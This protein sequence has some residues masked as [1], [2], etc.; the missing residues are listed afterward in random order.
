MTHATLFLVALLGHL[1]LWVALFNRLHSLAIP[2]RVQD[3]VEKWVLGGL[4]GGPALVVWAVH[5]RPELLFHPAE[6]LAGTPAVLGYAA[7]C[8]GMGTW[9]TVRWLQRKLRGP[10]AELLSQRREVSRLDRELGRLPCSDWPTRAWARVPGNQLLQVEVATKSL[11]IARLP[12]ALD[13]LRI[14]HLSDLHFSGRI[15]ADFFDWIVDRTNQ[16]QPD[17]VA[18]TGDLID[19]RRYLPWLPQILGRLQSP[20][21]TFCILG[22]HEL[23]LPDTSQLRDTLALAGLHYVGGRCHTLDIAGH[24]IFLAGN[25]L[26]W[27]GPAPDLRH[28]LQPRNAPPALRLLLAHTPDRFPWARR[29][30][31]DLMLAGHTHGGQICFPLVGPV[32]TQSRYGVSYCSG[33]YSQPPTVLH[34]SRGLSGCQPLRWNC[35]PELALLIL[36]NRSRAVGLGDGNGVRRWRFEMVRR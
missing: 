21:G 9:V 12:A 1:A 26:P 27:W 4:L 10:A 17:L 14:A 11:R 5:R 31:F 30:E 34:V 7:L 25:E 32:V 35:R 23:R 8:L 36:R 22:N 2:D 28:G 29:Y 20:G 16:L 13:G 19:H 15:T 3:H 6:L 33:V 24:R 18:I